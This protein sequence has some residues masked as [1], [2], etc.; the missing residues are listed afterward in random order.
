[1]LISVPVPATPV[2]MIWIVQLFDGTSCSDDDV[3]VVCGVSHERVRE[4]REKEMEA[5]AREICFGWEDA[6]ARR[7]GVEFVFV[8]GA[9]VV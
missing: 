2:P 6:G 9:K 1:M 8:V 7:W 4:V 5:E 3:V